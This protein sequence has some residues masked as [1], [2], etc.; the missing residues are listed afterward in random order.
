M[1]VGEN[2]IPPSATALLA[3]GE[4]PPAGACSHSHQ[5]QTPHC[6]L[7]N[8]KLA[9]TVA[10]SGNTQ[11][12]SYFFSDKETGDKFIFSDSGLRTL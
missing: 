8:F 6:R 3:A 2:P 10:L 4:S 5:K 12:D 1:G 9:N 7:R 11:D